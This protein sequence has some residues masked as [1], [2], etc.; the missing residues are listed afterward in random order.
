MNVNSR[1]RSAVTPIVAICEA[2]K[3]TGTA[4]TY[5]TFTCVDDRGE[6]FADDEP[7]IDVAMFRVNYFCPRTTNF[8]ATEHLLRRAIYNAF[9]NYPTITELYEDDTETN[10]IVFEFEVS[11][12]T[13]E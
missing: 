11:E 9:G 10:H 3:Y 1:I 2:T 8:K 13:E 5:C 6:V 4:T 12:E 7:I